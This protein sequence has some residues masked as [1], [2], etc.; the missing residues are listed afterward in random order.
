[1]TYSQAAK[2]AN[3]FLD[4]FQLLYDLEPLRICNSSE[5]ARPNVKTFRILPDRVAKG[6]SFP[7]EKP[8]NT[9]KKKKKLD[10]DYCPDIIYKVVWRN[11]YFEITL[12][13]DPDDLGYCSLLDDFDSSTYVLCDMVERRPNGSKKYQM[14]FGFDIQ[15]KTF[16]ELF[17]VLH[18]N[19]VGILRE[20][21]NYE[22]KLEAELQDV[23]II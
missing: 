4:V 20:Y 15:K 3:N 9:F 10:N 11:R 17:E 16:L 21:P 19:T 1:M 23:V 14:T 22:S 12:W 5:S 7:W 2:I 13:D 8:K 6:F 18:Y